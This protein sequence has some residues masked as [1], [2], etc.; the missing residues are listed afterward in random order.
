MRIHRF[1]I[2]VCVTVSA[3]AGV[4]R[5][6][7]T[8][9]APGWEGVQLE[10]VCLDVKQTYDEM[11]AGFS[12]PMEAALER[13]FNGLGVE[14][15]SST[16]ECG[17]TFGLSFHGKALAAEY[18]CILGSA[19][20][21]CFTGAQV[22]G[23][24]TLTG[25]GRQPWSSPFDFTFDPPHSI[26]ECPTEP[27]NAPPL[28]NFWPSMLLGAL[29]ELYGTPVVEVAMHDRDQEMREAAIGFL[30]GQGEA[31]VPLLIEA[32]QDRDS[33]VRQGA[34]IAL[35]AMEQ[36][37]VGAVPA[38][39]EALGDSDGLVRA[40]AAGSLR[41]ITGEGFGDDQKTWRRWLEEPNLEP[42]P[43]VAWNGIPIMPGAKL[44]RELGTQLMYQT[45]AACS[46]ASAFYEEK[47]A[48]AGWVLE[49][50]NEWAGT[51][52][53]KFTK[54]GDDLEINLSASG[55]PQMP[56]PPE[57][58]GTP[59]PTKEQPGCALQIFIMR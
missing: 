33:E 22:S 20:G 30:R 51:R 37:A 38:L 5:P 8:L 53:L 15:E 26:S 11:R 9:V 16:E 3:C 36:E 21:H 32:L 1:T 43:F 13:L 17:A 4:R 23:A 58:G 48:V 54:A 27:E 7:Q 46:E 41:L 52:S 28:N 2:L 29:A 34:A 57:P 49:E 42:T 39:V 45:E 18:T 24:F 25:Q 35:G 59:V 14:V 44:P 47:L 12:L 56:A 40:A 31:G 6:P 55:P 19:C 10:S 50:A